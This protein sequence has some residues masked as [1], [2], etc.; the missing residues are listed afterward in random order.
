MLDEDNRPASTCIR[1]AWCDGYPCLVHAKADAETIAV[2]PLLGLPNVTLL[3]GAEVTRLRTD[4]AGR[5][6]TEVVVS[7]DG[8]AGDVYARTSSCWPPVR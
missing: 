8:R 1:C 6:V 5:V 4:P 2:R 3:T 7:R